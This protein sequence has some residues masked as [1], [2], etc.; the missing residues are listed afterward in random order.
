VVIDTHLA[1]EL[2]N[3][4]FCAKDICGNPAAVYP[5]TTQLPVAAILQYVLASESAAIVALDPL[6]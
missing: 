1:L 4:A 2:V 3:V 5:L 6:L